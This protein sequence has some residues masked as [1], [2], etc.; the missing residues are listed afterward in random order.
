MYENWHAYV[1]IYSVVI[2]CTGSCHKFWHIY[3]AENSSKTIKMYFCARK[4]AII[5]SSTFVLFKKVGL[6]SIWPCKKFQ[7]YGGYQKKKIWFITIR[8]G[9]GGIEVRYWYRKILHIDYFWNNWYYWHQLIPPPNAV[10]GTPSLPA[11]NASVPAIDTPAVCLMPPVDSRSQPPRSSSSPVLFPPPPCYPPPSRRQGS[12]APPAIPV[13]DPALVS[14]PP[15]Q[16]VPLQAPHN[17]EPF[18]PPDSASVDKSKTSV[19]N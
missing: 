6:N 2:N 9:G 19:T 14:A 5:V 10:P 17:L 3:R 12:T 13:E 7:F 15:L 4:Q 1:K 8:R 18:S 16:V 11:V